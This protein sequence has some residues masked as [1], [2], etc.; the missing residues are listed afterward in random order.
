[1]T[2]WSQEKEKKILQKY[3]FTLTSRILR[4]LLLCAVI[5]GLYILSH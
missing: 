1:M 3:R 4:I 5:Y 2:E